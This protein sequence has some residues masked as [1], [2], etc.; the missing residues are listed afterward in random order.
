M[1]RPTNGIAILVLTPLD[2]VTFGRY[3][4]IFTV[5]FMT[6]FS[7]ALRKKEGLSDHLHLFAVNK[8][9]THTNAIVPVCCV[10]TS[11]A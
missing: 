3:E 11:F 8:K 7:R 10:P 9:E 1:N 2:G 4:F 6:H 5:L